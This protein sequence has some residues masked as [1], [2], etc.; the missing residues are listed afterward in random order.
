M[1][2]KSQKFAEA[3]FSIIPPEKWEKRINPNSVILFIFALLLL[4]NILPIIV[5]QILVDLAPLAPFEGD[6]QVA[7]YLHI[8]TVSGDG[9][10]YAVFYSLGGLDSIIVLFQVVG[11]ALIFVLFINN[12]LFD[13]KKTNLLIITQTIIFTFFWFLFVWPGTYLYLPFRGILTPLTGGLALKLGYFG[14]GGDP[15]MSSLLLFI[16][17]TTLIGWNVAFIWLHRHADSFRLYFEEFTATEEDKKVIEL[18][19][20]LESGALTI[21]VLKEIL[22]V[23]S[24]EEV[25]TQLSTTGIKYSK[26]PFLV[27]D[28]FVSAKQIRYH[29]QLCKNDLKKTPYWQCLQCKRFVCQEDYANLQQ[30]MGT[31]PSCV[32]CQGYFVSL[33]AQCNGCKVHYLDITQLGDKEY[34]SYCNNQIRLKNDKYL[35]DEK[36]VATLRTKQDQ[37]PDIEAQS[38]TKL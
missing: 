24:S 33:P 27:G 32:E 12:T 6:R 23:K 11:L 34:C 26:Y 9:G 29:C 4:Y 7:P 1:S 14:Q 18:F 21:D 17:P 36:R 16:I 28:N 38:S 2:S 30:T 5:I 3:L 22:R 13:K 31:A 8:E 25:F 10:I 20:R 15:L 35:S 19:D 37:Q